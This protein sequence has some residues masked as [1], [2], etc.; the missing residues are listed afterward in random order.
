[1][2]RAVAV[3]HE[4]VEYI[5]AELRDGVVYVSIQFATAVH[6]CCCG[7]GNYVVTPITPTDWKLIFD[8][9]TISL[10]PSIGNWSFPCRSHYW[11]RRNQVKW[12]AQWSHREIEVGRTLEQRAKENYYNLT[13]NTTPTAGRS[14]AHGWQA[15]SEM[16]CTAFSLREFCTAF[17]ISN[18]DG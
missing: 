12:A 14:G 6:R 10:D 8:G 7:C 13:P 2:R 4:F 17:W 15:G 5:P 11:I 18:A 1:V 3:R 16:S 9:E